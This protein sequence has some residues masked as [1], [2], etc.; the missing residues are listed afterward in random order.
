MGGE[1][2]KADKPS[3]VNRTDD[4]IALAR[5]PHPKPWSGVQGI[6][7]LLSHAASSSGSDRTVKMAQREGGKLLAW[8]CRWVCKQ[9]PLCPA[10]FR[11][12]AGL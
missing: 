5:C 4:P 12:K 8:S 3:L 2:K 10:N 1:E 6:W 11:N 9:D 7:N